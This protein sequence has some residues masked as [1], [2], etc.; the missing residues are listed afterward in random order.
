M[1]YPLVHPY[2]YRTVESV[3]DDGFYITGPA[4]F[5][6]PESAVTACRGRP[7]FAVAE[8]DPNSWERNGRLVRIIRPPADG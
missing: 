7:R 8:F 5:A 1:P 2:H 6:N 3:S 4:V